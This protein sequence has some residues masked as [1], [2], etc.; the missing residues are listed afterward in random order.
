MVTLKTMR[1]VER[2]HE[3]EHRPGPMESC[4]DCGRQKAKCRSKIFRYTDRDEAFNEARQ[5]NEAENYARPRTAYWCPW[6]GMYHHTT[7]L[8]TRRDAVQKQQRK[9][10]F[11]RELE[12]RARDGAGLPV[13][14]PRSA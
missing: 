8:R 1:N 2:W 10:M 6:C 13:D 7:K 3:K 9:W 12:R 4:W 14:V 5:M 11:Q